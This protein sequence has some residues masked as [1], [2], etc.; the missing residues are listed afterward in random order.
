M[1]TWFYADYK[2]LSSFIDKAGQLPLADSI[3]NAMSKSKAMSGN[4]RPTD[5]AV[6]LA[7]NKQGNMDVFPMIWGF[8][9]ESSTKPI[10]RNWDMRSLTVSPLMMN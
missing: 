9:L 10:M 8:T 7:P 4:I 2:P 3:M 6:V 1:C 5:M